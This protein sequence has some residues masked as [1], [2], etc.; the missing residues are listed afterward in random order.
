MHKWNKLY[1]LKN[2]QFWYGDSVI[3]FKSEDEVSNPGLSKV[4]I[5]SDDA[6]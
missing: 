3:D 5:G 1:F 2:D 4:F 6:I